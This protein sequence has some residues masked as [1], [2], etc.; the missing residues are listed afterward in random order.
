MGRR[1]RRISFSVTVLACLLYAAPAFAQT[2]TTGAM[3]GVVRDE[4]G[5]GIAGVTVVATSTATQTANSEITDDAGRYEISNLPPGTYNVVFY[6]SDLT[7][8]RTGVSVKLGQVVPVHAKIDTNQSGG[9]VIEI[10]GS[11]PTIDVGS[12]KQGVSIDQ[13]YTRNIPVPGRTFESALGAAPGSQGDLYGV[14]FS[15]SSS[16]ENSYIVDGVNTTGLNFGNVGSAVINDFI[17][18]TEIITGGY[19]AEFGRSTGGVVNVVT[20]SGTNEFK[21]SV[22]FNFRNSALTN[23]AERAPQDGTSIE[24]DVNLAYDTD[25]GFELGGPIVK[26]KVWFYVGFAPRLLKTNIDRFTQRQI[27]CRQVDPL[28][29]DFRRDAQ[30]RIECLPDLAANGGYADGMPDVDP[31]TDFTIYERIPGSD[32][33]L[34]DTT[35]Q[36]NFISKINFAVAPEHQGQVSV[37]GNPATR[38][39]VGIFGEPGTSRRNIQQ[40]TTS[41]GAKWTSKFNDNKTEVEASLGWYRSKFNSE[42]REDLFNNRALQIIRF[43]QLA[44]HGIGGRETDATLDFCRDSGMPNGPDRYPLIDNC[45]DHLG[46]GYRVNGVGGIGDDLEERRSIKLA[47]SQRVRAAGHH[48]FKGG[49]DIESNLTEVPRHL[50]GGVFYDT[51]LP[52]GTFQPMVEANRFARIDPIAG[53]RTCGADDDGNPIACEFFEGANPATGNTLNWSAFVQDSWSIQP[54]LTLNAGLRYEEQRLRYSAELQNS[55]DPITGKELGKNA[56]VMDNMWAPRIGLIYDWTK[57]GRSKVYGHWGRFFESIPMRINERSFGGETFYIQRWG[58]GQCGDAV[59]FIG[60]PSGDNCPDGSD[61]SLQPDLG[62]FLLGSGVIVQPGVKPQYMDEIVLGVEYEAFEDVRV[63]VAYKNRRLGRVLEDVS[64]DNADTYIIA[65][66][67]EFDPDEEAR[68]QSEIDDMD[69]DV[70]ADGNGISDK[71]EAQ[72]ELDGFRRVRLFDKAKRDYNSI[73]LIV[74]KRFSRNFFVQAAY[75][76]ARTEGNFGGLFSADT[77]Q[78]DP[79]IT[80]QFDLIELLANRDGPLPQDRPHYFKFDGYYTWDFEKY[81]Q[82]TTGVRLRALSGIPQ[83]ALGRHYLYGIGESY[84]L[85]RGSVGR[86]EFEK[87]ADIHIG[88]GRDLG[89]GYHLEGFFDMFNI[90]ND[91][92]TFDVDENYTFDPANPIVGGTDEDLVYL[93]ET[94]QSTGLE[95]PEPVGR[96]QNFG[97][98][99]FRYGPRFARV[100]LRLTF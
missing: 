7:Y 61:P 74:T 10:E 19:N 91:Q 80:S 68:L 2:D 5:N 87:S 92:G 8:K 1:E 22:F 24:A 85:P 6:Y 55:K 57:E 71:E 48:V 82:L 31:E 73:E 33:R 75:T 20:K 29:G 90:A 3:Q 25:F 4:S 72:A 53:S 14:S 97:N 76:Y 32:Q 100:G 9:E 23:E 99:R 27:D 50:S 43:G 46:V 26:D 59:D 39:S 84:L 30:G 62:D 18:E 93:K 37:Q 60:G 67:G 69:A 88:Y 56:L 64:V 47:G 95:I 52:N 70:D 34:A 13:D 78:L 16:L 77:G 49:I 94:T 98:P 86:N 12:T 66:P 28:T 35:Q 36:Y 89:K 42:S 38:S 45:P 54:N 11:A 17:Q 65:N 79:N 15:G 58:I 83:D 44:T 41:V 21:G 51:I 96:N 81:G 63:G 40:I